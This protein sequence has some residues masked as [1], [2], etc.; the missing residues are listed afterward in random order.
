MPNNNTTPLEEL[1][2]ARATTM[3]GEGDMSNPVDA[4]TPDQFMP[5]LTEQLMLAVDEL[6]LMSPHLSATLASQ[7]TYV[8]DNVIETLRERGQEYGEDLLF[9]TGEEGILLMVVWKSMRMLWSM[10]AGL[11]YFNRRDGWRDLAGYALI[12]PAMKLYHEDYEGHAPR[13][14]HGFVTSCPE[15]CN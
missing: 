2:A 10:Q 14:K 3:A 15:S 1:M 13:C 9:L 6:R 4:P 12:A 5:Y 8:S 7:M 11:P